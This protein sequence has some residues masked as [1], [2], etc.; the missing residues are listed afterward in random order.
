MQGPNSYASADFYQKPADGN[1]NE[2][3]LLHGGINAYL[4][5]WSSDRKL[6]VYSQLSQKTANDLFLL[7]AQ[8]EGEQKPVPYLQTPANEY[9]AR[10]SPDGHWMAYVSDE[11]GQQVYI[12]AVPATDA[13]WQIS[14]S[15]VA[16]GAA[17]LGPAWRRDGKELYYISA[18]Q[19]LM[20]VPIKSG[21][22]VEPGTPQA[23]FSV[24]RITSYA[25]SR[26]GQRFLVNVPAG[27][28]VS[29][30]SPVTVITNWQTALKK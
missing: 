15:A 19:K 8:G 13:K 20:A 9:S 3:L 11:S 22:T 17:G 28:E 30:V 6:I 10:F 4:N 1:G 2:Q 29:A 23:L 27:G 24:P 7:P 5:D 18:E 12:Q 21:S 16:A 14:T 26:D 25:P